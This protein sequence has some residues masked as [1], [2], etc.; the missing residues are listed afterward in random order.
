MDPIQVPL[1]VGE[2]YQLL[3]CCDSALESVLILSRA[4]DRFA[5]AVRYDLYG[6][7]T[8]F[9]PV[10]GVPVG[11]TGAVTSG[12][13]M[14]REVAAL[15]GSSATSFP[16]TTVTGTFVSF[17]TT[18]DDGLVFDLSPSVEMAAGS[19]PS[20]VL[21]PRHLVMPGASLAYDLRRGQWLSV[22]LHDDAASSYASWWFRGELWTAAVRESNQE[23]H[24]AVYRFT[25]QAS[26]VVPLPTLGIRR[27]LN[28][29]QGEGSWRLR[30]DPDDA[31]VAWLERNRKRREISWPDGWT[32]VFAPDLRVI[33]N[34]G[35]VVARQGT[36]CKPD[37]GGG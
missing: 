26:G 16:G 35:H 12:F 7:G 4:S 33:A 29:C 34:D 23:Y 3:A 27:G 32:A 9:F 31:R 10:G 15:L 37:T 30:G 28:P 14:E 18:L 19:D 25:P 2:S 1:P 17:A 11:G 21:A 6:P 36:R 24:G 13:S 20:L 5:E 22:P 8:P